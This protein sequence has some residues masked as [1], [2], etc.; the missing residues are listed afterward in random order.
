MVPGVCS[1]L[2]V[3]VKVNTNICR[4]LCQCIVMGRYGI[5]LKDFSPGT[6]TGLLFI[7][8]DGVQ[9]SL[10]I[11]E[12]VRILTWTTV[13]IWPLW[14]LDSKTKLLYLYF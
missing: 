13:Y 3:Y 2:S 6:V 1:D 5:A 11:D 12:Y 8:A 14:P 10:D 4:R 7:R 9:P